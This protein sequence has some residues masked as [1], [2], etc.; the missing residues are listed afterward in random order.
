MDDIGE[1]IP[2][3]TSGIL[4]NNGKVAAGAS[5]DIS[6]FASEAHKALNRLCAIT[7]S[8]THE[9]PTIKSRKS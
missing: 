4:S 8:P 9:G 7:M 5:T 6:A 1:R 2:V 3:L